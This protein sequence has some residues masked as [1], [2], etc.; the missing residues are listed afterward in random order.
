MP[1][2][3]PLE[4]YARPG[5]GLTFKKAESNGNTLT[6]PCGQCMGCRIRR[7][8]EWAVRIC[9]EASLHEENQFITLTYAPEH[10][11]RSGSLQLAHWQNFMK[12]YRKA[13]DKKLRFFMCGEYGEKLSR[14]HYHAA[15]FGHRFDD[16][17]LLNVAGGN[18]LYTS[19]QLETLWRKGMVS[20]GDLT[21]QS[22]A[23][24]A[25]YVTKKINGKAAGDHYQTVNTETGEI[26]RVRPEFVTM[27]RRPGIA[28]DWFEM[29]KDDVYP[30]DFVVMKGKKYP[31]PRYYDKL[32]ATADQEYA[33]DM[34]WERFERSYPLR[35]DSTPERLAVKKECFEARI[36]KLK[37]GYESDA[38]QSV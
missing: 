26:F 29:F 6:V 3:H 31:T 7:S 5:G 10:L 33:E 4:G 18:R 20:I 23:Y 14:P 24:V 30:D 32:L 11:P 15:I 21:P 36:S 38:S 27:S 13:T 16:L 37:R 28:H 34:K 2:F 12:R 25:R 1:C 8:Q 9:H 35:L 22:A 19:P 17:E